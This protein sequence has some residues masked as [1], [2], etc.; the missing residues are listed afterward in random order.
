MNNSTISKVEAY[1]KAPIREVRQE[2][3]R[4]VQYGEEA[5]LVHSTDVGADDSHLETFYLQLTEEQFRRL[6]GHY[7]SSRAE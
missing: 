2:I 1:T 7:N 3:D 5:F 4:M 6:G